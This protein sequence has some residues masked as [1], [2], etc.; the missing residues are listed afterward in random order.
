[1]KTK[2]HSLRVKPGSHVL[3]TAQSHI[4]PERTGG[5]GAVKVTAADC[6]LKVKDEK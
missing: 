2:G 5:D 3:V 1:M 4:P 6:K